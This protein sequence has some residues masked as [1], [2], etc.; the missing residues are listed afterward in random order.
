MHHA[1]VVITT[2]DVDVD[3]ASIA[4]GGRACFLDKPSGP[5]LYAGWILFLL[6]VCNIYDARRSQNTVLDRFSPKQ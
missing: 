3:V 1:P 6:V 5:G 2:G 4:R